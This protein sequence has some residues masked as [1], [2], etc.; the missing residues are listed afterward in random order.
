[1]KQSKKKKNEPNSRILCGQE[2]SMYVCVYIYYNIVYEGFYVVVRL[3]PLHALSELHTGTGTFILPR[4]PWPLMPTPTPGLRNR[5]ICSAKWVVPG[6]ALKEPEAPV[7]RWCLASEGRLSWRN[8][9]P[10]GSPREET[11]V[12]GEKRARRTWDARVTPSPHRSLALIV[13]SPGVESVLWEKVSKLWFKSQSLL[14]LA[15]ETSSS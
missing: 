12:W 8:F 13:P 4:P 10:G 1:M 2:N 9:R 5:Q 11:F 6:C 15:L 3:T 14:L 7:D